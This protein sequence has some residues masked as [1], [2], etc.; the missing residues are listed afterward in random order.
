VLNR[1]L[2]ER[3]T[4]GASSMEAA[5]IY[6]DRGINRKYPQTSPRVDITIATE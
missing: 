2:E 1:Q 4:N 6:D 3:I 5:R